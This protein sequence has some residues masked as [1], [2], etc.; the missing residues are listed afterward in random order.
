VT[1]GARAAALLAAAALAGCCT[2]SRS[3]SFTYRSADARRPGDAPPLD[4]A[5]RRFLHLADFGDE[6]CQQAQVAAAVDEAHRRDAFDAAFFAGDLVYECGADAAAPGADACV[7]GPDG[8]TVLPA[9]PP[10]TAAASFRAH[11]APLAS[12]ARPPAA[13]VFVALGNHDVAAW[14]GCGGGPDPAEVARRKACL[15]VAH[16]SPLWTMPGRHYAVDRGPARFVVVDSNLLLGDYGGFSFEDEVA[17]VREAA[18]ACRADACEAE[19]GGCERPWCF[20]VAHHPAATA[21]RHRD[22]ATPEV[23]ARVAR[24]VEAGGG[25]IRAWLAGHDHDLQHLRTAAGLDVFVSGN[26]AR[27]RPDERFRETSAPGARVIFASV[28]WGLG[29][30]EVAPSGWRYRFAGVDG[31]PLYCCAAV[32]PARCEPARCE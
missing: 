8:N 26:G 7:F 5:A 21:G 14:G 32:G 24:L 16:R 9:L 18:G 25:R 27:G 6:T 17:F 1:R 11:E 29:V 4:G 23:L 12:L 22:E 31:E 28:A 15:S 20:L 19:P 3:P 30:L 2:C 13:E 10:E